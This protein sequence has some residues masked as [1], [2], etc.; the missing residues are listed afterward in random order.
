MVQSSCDLVSQNPG[1]S[2]GFADALPPEIE[3]PGAIIYEAE[4]CSVAKNLIELGLPFAYDNCSWNIS[5]LNNAPDYYVSGDN[6]VVWTGSDE[7]NNS[8]TCNQLVTINCPVYTEE[9][10]NDLVTIYPNPSHGTIFIHSSSPLENASIIICNL[11]GQSV[12][13]YNN[14][15]LESN[16][17]YSINNLNS[18]IYY[19]IV[20]TNNKTHMQ[21]LLIAI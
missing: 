3:C 16:E 4:S 11:M 14:I 2:D 9:V 1:Y 21:K 15:N 17:Q 13:K 7:A 19:V 6:L 10:L 5:Y 12:K 8:S 18:G 20:S